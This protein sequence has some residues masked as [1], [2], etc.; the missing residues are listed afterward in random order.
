MSRSAPFQYLASSLFSRREQVKDGDHDGRDQYGF[1]PDTVH[2]SKESQFIA[3]EL[4]P[5][6]DTFVRSASAL[7]QNG[8]IAPQRRNGFRW[9]GYTVFDNWADGSNGEPLALSSSRP[10][11]QIR[12][13]ADNY[14]QAASRWIR[15][16][17]TR[18]KLNAPRRCG[19]A[20]T[21]V[22][23]ATRCR[24]RSIASISCPGVCC[25]SEGGLKKQ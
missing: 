4:Q 1:T 9:V 19:G 6:D 18:L 25:S 15:P 3:R 12:F 2:L 7:S 21:G 13:R 14:L 16:M 11:R 22:Y 5:E 23:E 24:R 20:A 17:A 8:V 10:V